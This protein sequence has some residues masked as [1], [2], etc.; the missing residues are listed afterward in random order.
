LFDAEIE[1]RC[2]A[3]LRALTGDPR[4]QWSGQRLYVGDTDWP[5]QAAHLVDTTASEADQRAVTDA[6]ALRLLHSDP[7]LYAQHQP[8]AAIEAMLYELLEQLRVESLADREWRGVAANL[9]GRFSRW[10]ESFVGSGLLETALGMLLFTLSQTVWSRLTGH[11]IRET[12]SDMIE[13]TR[14]N[15]MPTLGPH[16]TALRR[17]RAEQSAYIP[18]ALAIA[19]W[20]AEACEA[21]LAEQSLLPRPSKRRNNFGLPLNLTSSQAAPPPVAPLGESKVWQAKRQRYQIYTRAFDQER[22]ASSLA[23]PEQLQALREQID[24]DA[25]ASQHAVPH[26]ARWLR[27]QLAEPQRDGWQFEQDSGLIDGKRLS[28][29]VSQSGEQRVFKTE[30]IAPQTDCAVTLLLDCSGS[31]KGH[32]AKLAVLVDCLGRALSMAGVS[33][34]ILGYSTASW[35]GGQALKQWQKSGQPAHPGRLNATQHLIFKS[36][37]QTWQQG[38]Q[39]LALLHRADLF[40][41]GIDGEALQWACQRLRQAEA[42]RLLL[43][44]VSDGCP[45]DS[46]TQA[47]NDSHY[48]DQHL[49]QVIQQESQVGD[50]ALRALGVGLDLGPFY[51]H[52]LALSLDD[53]LDTQGLL[54][55]ARLLVLG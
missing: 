34:E 25:Q 8:K 28:L 36:H 26:L 4:L 52:R 18:A 32:A 37:Q 44:A 46:A 53:A 55:V 48:L 35:H 49:K 33:V 43:L 5:L 38:R 7:A 10:S 39:G 15:L 2:Q 51:R 45:M 16:F 11:E 17:H 24:Q 30:Q 9:E 23:R 12:W 1:S 3:A 21:A 40:R 13:T 29:L 22:Q 50:I 6:A 14:G 54:R 19:S 31:M 42:S 27:Q 20:A 47:H 41:E